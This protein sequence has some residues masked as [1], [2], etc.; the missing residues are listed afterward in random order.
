MK[1]ILKGM[2]NGLGALIAFFSWI[3]IPKKIKRSKEEQQKIDE[4]TKN[5]ELYQFFGCPFCIKIRRNITK[6]NLNITTRNAQS[7]EKYRNE[8]LSSG[9]KIQVPCLKITKDDTVEWLYE[10]SAITVYLEDNFGS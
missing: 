5:I 9:G 3:L 10:S 2:R 7:D 1:I 6:L 4:K 8:L